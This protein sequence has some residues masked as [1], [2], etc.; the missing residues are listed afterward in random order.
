[1]QLNKL[2]YKILFYQH[3]KSKEFTKKMA[4]K[5]GASTGFDKPHSI[6]KSNNH[7][8]KKSNKT[9]SSTQTRQVVVNDTGNSL[10][11]TI[12]KA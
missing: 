5:I 7:Q 4:S 8:E 9:K 12:L 1:M 3:N 2:F 6:I 11:R 10:N